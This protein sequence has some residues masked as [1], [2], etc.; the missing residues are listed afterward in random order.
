MGYAAQAHDVAFVY[1]QT[2]SARPPA[3]IEF[4]RW[5]LEAGLLDTVVDVVR[6][7]TVAGTGYPYAIETADAAAVIRAA[8]RAQFYALFQAF[9]ERAGLSFTFSH[10]VLSKSRRRA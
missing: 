8:D 1:L 4:P 9:V 5:V 3:R 7:E 2:A 6:A 10:K